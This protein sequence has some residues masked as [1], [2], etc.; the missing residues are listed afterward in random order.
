MKTACSICVIME[1]LEKLISLGEKLG[2]SDEGLQ[3]FVKAE[4]EK[5]KT[6]ERDRKEREERLAQREEQRL[7]REAEE[8]EAVRDYEAKQREAERQHQLEMAKLRATQSQGGKGDDSG[9][10]RAPCPK[11]PPF[12]E[13]K[14]SLDAYIER[15]ERFAKSQKW[16]EENWAVSLSAL[17]KGKALDVY[18]RLPV[19]DALDY[20][21]LKAALLKR[22]RMT[23]DGYRLKFRTCRPERN[24]TPCQFV[25]RMCSYMHKWVELSGTAEDYNSLLDLLLHSIL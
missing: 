9:T 4:Q 17:L 3:N 7:K 24:E 18:S 23:E 13:S 22:Y 14:D 11:I 16:P 15:Y 20:T 21:K 19:E 12:D 1:H 25:A 6:V 5:L 10:I 8:R 2:Y